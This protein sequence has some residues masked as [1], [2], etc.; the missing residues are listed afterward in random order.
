MHLLLFSLAAIMSFALAEVPIHLVGD[1]IRECTVP[2]KH[3]VISTRIDA[4]HS[5]I[6]GVCYLATNKRAILTT[7]FAR[8]NLDDRAVDGLSVI[9]TV[10][11]PYGDV[12]ERKEPK[13]S[14]VVTCDLKTCTLV[15]DFVIED[16]YPKIE[17]EID[18]G[19]FRRMSPDKVFCFKQPVKIVG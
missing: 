15:H 9:P 10:K 1:E 3:R 7:V 4:C 12:V 18:Y 17:V 6:D 14:Y 16:V 5:Y 19:V 2:G 11:I 13:D 8:G